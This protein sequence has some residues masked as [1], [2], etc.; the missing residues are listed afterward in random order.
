MRF[1][2]CFLQGTFFLKVSNIILIIGVICTTLHFTLQNIIFL[3]QT[4]AQESATHGKFI[5]S[6][7]VLL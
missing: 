6:L 1:A 5:F 2:E 7:H 4:N 3:A